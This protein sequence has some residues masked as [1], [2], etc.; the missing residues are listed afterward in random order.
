MLR[1]CFNFWGAYVY[2]SCGNYTL[3]RFPR[4]SVLFRPGRWDHYYLSMSFPSLELL[5][6]VIRLFVWK[7][8]YQ[9]LIPPQWKTSPF[10]THR[11]HDHGGDDGNERWAEIQR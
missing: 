9:F 11:F 1:N 5:M 4:Q 2:F 10:L 6:C 3:F 8:N 7:R